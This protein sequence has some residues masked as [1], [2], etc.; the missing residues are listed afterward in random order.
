MKLLNVSKKYNRKIVLSDINLNLN[1]GIYGLLGENG[2]G[3]TTLIKIMIGQI[4]QN[5]GS[6]QY[7][8]KNIIDN[9]N[10]Y[11][12]LG[13]VPQ[14]F[15]APKGMKIREY[16]EYV[17]S[18]KNIAGN[19]LNDRINNLCKNMSLTKY[20]D[21]KIG[22]LSGG[23]LKRL[24]IVQAFLNNPKIIILDEPTAGLDISER[25]NLKQFINNISDRCSVIISTHIVSDIEDIANNLILLNE[26][27]IIADNDYLFELNKLSGLV[28]EDVGNSEYI[29]KLKKEIKKTD[30]C[31]TNLRNDDTDIKRIRYVSKMKLTNSSIQKK[32]E[33]ND[34][35]L[36]KIGKGGVKSD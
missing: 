18:Y 10:F 14:H 8:G 21:V 6:V 7:N 15:T 19:T 36:W 26:G 35:Y 31:I 34:Y 30:S 33:L 3:K 12:D 32:G 22:K 24:G 20:M 4:I 13:Y 16:L 1:N 27:K 29:E 17:G 25:N 28:W 5:S 11:N 23:T 9:S 2:A